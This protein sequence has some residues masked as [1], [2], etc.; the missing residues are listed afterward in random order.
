MDSHKNVG[1]YRSTNLEVEEHG[2]QYGVRIGFQMIMYKRETKY[3][4]G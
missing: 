4:N 3:K 2:E 1:T